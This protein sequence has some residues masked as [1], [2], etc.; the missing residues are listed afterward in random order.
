MLVLCLALAAG[1]AA[2]APEAGQPIN[3]E[4]FSLTV[5]DSIRPYAKAQLTLR[6]PQAGSLD[7]DAL[8]HGERIPLLRGLAVAAG[9]Q[10]LTLEGLSLSGEPLPRGAAVLEAR[11]QTGVGSLGAQADVMVQAAAIGLD[12]ALLSRQALHQTGGED[13]Y[14]DYQLSRPGLLQ[15]RLYSQDSPG[16]TLQSWNIERKDDLPHAFRWNRQVRGK[17]APPGDYLL[18]FQ[19]RGSEQA[20]FELPFT[21]LEG[22]EPG[23]PLSISQPGDFLPDSLEDAAVW[24]AMMA[25]LVVVDIG[26]LAHQAIYERPDSA[27]PVLGY[28]HGQTAGLQVLELD[29]GGF[30][31]V[32]AARH[33]DGQ[34]VRGYLPRQRLMV[35][36]PHGRYGLLVDKRAQTLTVYE[37]G[38]PLGQL[39]I[40]TGIYLP[41]GDSSFDTLQGA[42]L[43]QDRIRE[44]SSE[45][46]RYAYATRIDGGNLI[47]AAG[48]QLTGGQRSWH[49]QQAQLGAPASHGCVRVD[50]RV[51]G[52]GLNAWWLYAN[53]PR[54]TKVLV[55]DGLD[56]RAEP[57]AGGEEAADAK[58][59]ADASAAET[60]PI[61]EA[62]LPGDPLPGPTFQVVEEGASGTAQEAT[63][64]AAGGPVQV[65]MSFGGDCVL[66]SEEGR[67]NRPGS[68]HQVVAEHGLDWPFSALGT[69][70]Q[71]DDLSLVNLENVLQDDRAGM[72]SRQHNFRGPASFAQILRLGGIDLVNLANNH[73]V[74]Y[75]QPG[76][77]STRRA[78]TEA[79]VP[80]AGF[81]SLYVYEKDGIRIGFAGIRETTFHQ[82]RQKMA[83]EIAELKRQG[84]HYIVYTCHFGV[85]YAPRHNEVQTLM[86]KMAIDAGANLVIGHHPHVV[87]GIEEY[88]EGL[89]FYSLGNLVF[90]GNLELT[91][92]DG[93][94]AQVALTF[95]DETLLETRVRLVPVITSGTRPDNDFRPHIAKGEDRE[96]ILATIAADSLK[97]YPEAFTLGSLD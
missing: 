43:T 67:F 16:E 55:V 47:H 21:L 20:A 31:L 63:G 44:F 70:F 52:E 25:P 22:E 23:L 40:S 86:A 59:A 54:N 69:L 91:T 87:Q 68:F 29:V 96:R 24:Q 57:A 82:G 14:V 18:T 4:G 77:N 42:F 9:E 71:Q 51:S 72:I 41:P 64:K 19:A 93:L 28:V 12:Y 73:F 88:G 85:E 60:A 33:G 6:L 89:I 26:D 13:L 75:G 74:D 53:L 34:W 62:A 17:P 95:E 32:R 45:G 49:L 97:A 58:A 2:G 15:V 90:G 11:L 30:A 92:F 5:P 1:A 79:G 61:T 8:A 94:V 7:L 37:Q 38:R 76:R 10:A 35:V 65:L 46:F 56:P 27:S 3:G 50:T 78:L 66:G 36:R 39:A 83:E 81:N 84:C 80:Y 48:Y